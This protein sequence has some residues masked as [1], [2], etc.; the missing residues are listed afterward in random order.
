MSNEQTQPRGEGWD[1]ISKESTP[2][3][4]GDDWELP[5]QGAQGAACGLGPDSGCEACQ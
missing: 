5:E 3:I 2:E 1:G 4:Q